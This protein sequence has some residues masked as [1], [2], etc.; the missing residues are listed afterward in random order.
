MLHNISVE[1]CS[2]E[3]GDGRGH[4]SYVAWIRHDIYKFLLNLQSTTNFKAIFSLHL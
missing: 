2:K 4:D 1:I 3:A